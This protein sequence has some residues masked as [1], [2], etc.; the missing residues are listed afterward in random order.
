[1]R[2][3][4]KSLGTEERD[5]DVFESINSDYSVILGG[6]VKRSNLV[7]RHL[8]LLKSKDEF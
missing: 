7:D 1:M 5:I 3:T 4:I 8:V 2:L 6:E